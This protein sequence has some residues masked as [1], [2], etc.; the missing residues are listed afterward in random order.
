M[1]LAG[2][3]EI[4]VLVLVRMEDILVDRMDLNA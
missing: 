1:V 3:V 4:V 2:M